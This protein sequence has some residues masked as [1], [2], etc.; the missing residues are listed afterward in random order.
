MSGLTLLDALAEAKIAEAIARA[1]WTISPAR[2]RPDKSGP[3]TT[4]LFVGA[5]SFARGARLPRR[6]R[7]NPA[8]DV[9]SPEPAGYL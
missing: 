6:G 5:N 4:E 1:R 2:A 9:T 7:I 8:L 3:T